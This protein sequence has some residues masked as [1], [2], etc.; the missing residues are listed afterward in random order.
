MDKN[1]QQDGLVKCVENID[2][3][4]MGDPNLPPEQTW[5]KEEERQALRKLD[6]VLIP[7]SVHI[8]FPPSAIHWH[9]EILTG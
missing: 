9:E 7:L 2:A 5:T 1:I 3:E 4:K 8:L 6:I